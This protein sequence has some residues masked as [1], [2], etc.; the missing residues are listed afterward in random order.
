MLTLMAG[1][2]PLNP[3]HL[4]TLAALW[5]ALVALAVTLTRKGRRL[6][7]TPRQPDETACDLDTYELAALA[8]GGGG[9]RDTA[10]VHLT[11]S[12]L[13]RLEPRGRA[14]VLVADLPAD[15]HPVET[16]FATAIRDRPRT[17]LH[18]CHEVAC[19]LQAAYRQLLCGHDLVVEPGRAMGR[20]LLA[21]LAWALPLTLSI[22]AI[23]A[24]AQHPLFRQRPGGTA[25]WPDAVLVAF[26]L[27]MATCC[28][29]LL[30]TNHTL[31][32][33]R[34]GDALLAA[35]RRACVALDPHASASDFQPA[36]AE[37][38]LGVAL[39]G[40]PRWAAYPP[41]REL[42]AAL[43]PPLEPASAG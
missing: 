42:H 38:A 43:Y 20:L 21:S 17:W 6:A 32:R 3:F 39:F 15:A 13:L 12:G 19:R 23:V 26:A 8:G 22:L 37:L 11:A 18:A 10:L 33:N 2:D 28:V 16:A 34:R 7:L 9:L 24:I 35:K 30:R 5:A 27:G 14:A 41:L 29:G 1:V 25:D 31:Y 4:A 36:P 40:L